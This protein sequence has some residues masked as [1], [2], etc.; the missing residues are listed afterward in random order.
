MLPKAAIAEEPASS[1]I[2]SRS[3]GGKE[4]PG[5]SPARLNWVKPSG[6]SVTVAVDRT[7]PHSLS[8]RRGMRCS[9]GKT[10]VWTHYRYSTE[11][12]L[13]EGLK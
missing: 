3:P 9:S 8:P 11:L 12:V 1:A 4:T 7:S 13:A 6:S 10:C 5:K 2:V